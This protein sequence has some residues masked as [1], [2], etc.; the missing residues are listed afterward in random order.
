MQIH[1]DRQMQMQT[2]YKYAAVSHTA[3][4]L[5]EKLQQLHK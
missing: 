3:D 2:P 1:A 4:S 5:N